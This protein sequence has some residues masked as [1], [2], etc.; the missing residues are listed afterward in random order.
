MGD[1]TNTPGGEDIG[2]LI[3]QFVVVRDAIA[4]IKARHDEELKE[5]IALQE[6]LRGK[7]QAFMDMNNLE[8][9]KTEHG[10]CYTSTKHT[11]SLA[12][13]DAF[14]NYV[15]DNKAFD[16]LDRRANV[17]AVKDF[18]DEHKCLPP[19]CNLSAIQTVGVRRAGSGK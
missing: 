11:A 4:K 3:Q 10:T 19:G 14:M 8:N 2:R 9:L 17:T 6:L 12:D 7:L 1:R 18:V 16:L 5:G 13:A 15:I